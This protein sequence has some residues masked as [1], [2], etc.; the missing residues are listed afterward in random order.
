V[1]S[2]SGGGPD[3]LVD[4]IGNYTAFNDLLGAPA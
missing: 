1:V 4:V 3:V 2:A